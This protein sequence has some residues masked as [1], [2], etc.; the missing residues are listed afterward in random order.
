MVGRLSVRSTQ[1]Y[2]GPQIHLRVKIVDFYHIPIHNQGG[3][4]SVA[5]TDLAEQNDSLFSP[6]ID[7]LVLNQLL[8]Q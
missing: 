2:F 7:I 3:E 6:K 8:I 4:W 1:N 5:I